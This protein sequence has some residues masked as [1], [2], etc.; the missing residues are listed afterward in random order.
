MLLHLKTFSSRN[1]GK[2]TPSNH[3]NLMEIYFIAIGLTSTE[4]IFAA[5]VCLAINNEKQ[6]IPANMFTIVSFGL[7]ILAIR[8]LSYDSLGEK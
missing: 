1:D 3:I 6:P 5:F 7:T 8:C 2:K 4:K